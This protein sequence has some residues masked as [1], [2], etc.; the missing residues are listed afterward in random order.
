M[1]WNIVVMSKYIKN[2]IK[3]LPGISGLVSSRDQLKLALDEAVK[4]RETLQSETRALHHELSQARAEQDEVVGQ[5][6]ELLVHRDK[7]IS[8]ARRSQGFVPA[9]HFYSPLPSIDEIRNDEARIF[10]EPSRNLAGIAL[11]EEAQLDLLKKFVP[12][13]KEMP[14]QAD[15]QENLRYYYEN[16]A[17]SYSDAILLHCMIR[18]LQPERII[19]V[20][21]GFSS[22]M[23]LD[24]NELFM[25][26]SIDTTFIEPYPELL[27]SLIKEQDKNRIKL[28]PGRLQEVDLNEFEALRANDILFIDSTHVSKIGSDVNRI[29]FDILPGLSSGVYVHF[30]DIFYPFEYPKEWVYE[31]RAWNEAY[32][33]RAFLQNNDA[34]SIVLMNSYLQH[35]H[36]SFLEKN[37]PLCLTNTGSIW[38][39]K[40]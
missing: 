11:N 30:H 1:K 39:R 21:S 16:D 17:F 33:L 40:N 9:G 14:F 8:E 37:L 3:K 28:V 20:G 32:L 15:K 34:F 19:E 29:L 6:T 22:C 24:T 23:T 2:A 18:E 10:G 4:Q 26:G 35:F 36:K 25:D 38:I 12:Y 7:L 5:R 27:M 13:Y 31:G